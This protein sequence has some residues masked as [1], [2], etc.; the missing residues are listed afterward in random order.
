MDFHGEADRNV[1][2]HRRS[3]ELLKTVQRW[4]RLLSYVRLPTTSFHGTWSGC[5]PTDSTVLE[6]D[7]LL[8]MGLQRDG[9]GAW[10]GG[11][12]AGIGVGNGS[13]GDP[14]DGNRAKGEEAAE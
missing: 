4:R 10:V 9:H 11:T 8:G 5:L 13:D 2:A 3:V 1:H 6:R 14:V 7:S 12:N